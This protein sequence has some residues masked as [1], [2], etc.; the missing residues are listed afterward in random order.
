MVASS[1]GTDDDDEVHADTNGEGEPTD[2]A[3]IRVSD[4]SDDA[5]DDG[6]GRGLP[7]SLGVSHAFLD[8]VPRNSEVRSSDGG[9]PRCLR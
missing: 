1:N 9:S 4:K 7:Y 5:N 8:F 6:D 3:A 2:S